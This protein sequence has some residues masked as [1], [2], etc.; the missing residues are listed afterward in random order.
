[1]KWCIWHLLHLLYMSRSEILSIYLSIYI[2][3]FGSDIES[4]A[5]AR[6]QLVQPGVLNTDTS[7]SR[8][9]RVFNLLSGVN[10]GSGLLLARRGGQWPWLTPWRRLNTLLAVLISTLEVVECPGDPV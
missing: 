2:S 5:V 9:K 4:T 6:P 3:I 8:P 1:M 7:V 10:Q